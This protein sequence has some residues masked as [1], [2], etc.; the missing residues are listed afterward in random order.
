[1]VESPI[2]SRA[3]NESQLPLNSFHNPSKQ[4]HTSLRPIS[5]LP[6]FLFPIPIRRSKLPFVVIMSASDPYHSVSVSAS[7]AELSA[8]KSLSEVL[9]LVL[10]LPV[11]TSP[12]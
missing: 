5:P 11:S 9:D 2:S 10:V 12:L 8:G 1:M 7:D 6:P 3:D 4:P